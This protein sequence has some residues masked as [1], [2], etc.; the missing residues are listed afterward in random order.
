MSIRDLARK[1]MGLMKR[2]DT[3]VLLLV[4]AGGKVTRVWII[5]GYCTGCGMT[6]GVRQ[7]NLV[8]RSDPRRHEAAE[9]RLLRPQRPRQMI[10]T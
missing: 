1:T 10:I 4:T 5:F 8:R 7:A 9:D 6:N 2:P 3:D